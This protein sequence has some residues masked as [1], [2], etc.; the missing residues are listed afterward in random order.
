MPAGCKL[1]SRD[2]ASAFGRVR[3]EVSDVTPGFLAIE[4]HE[5]H[6]GLVRLA[7]SD[8][9]PQTGPTADPTQ[10]TRYVARFDDSDAALMHAHERMKRRL[11]DADSHLYRVPLERAV[12]AIE[13]IDLRHRQIY[14]DPTL[15]REQLATIEQ[16]AVRYRN[17][18]RRLD[19]LFRTLGY[20]GVGILILNLLTFSL[21]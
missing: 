15:E 2:D 14:L 8:R 19:R 6:A 21:A 7:I 11:V 3:R 4:T 12:A 20:I 1:V 10:R 13:S 17:R 18:R 16:L 5:R 9:A